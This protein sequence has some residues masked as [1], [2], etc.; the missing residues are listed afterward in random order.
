M[1]YTPSLFLITL[2]LLSSL[3]LFAVRFVKNELAR[4]R[5]DLIIFMQVTYAGV[6]ISHGWRL[7]PILIFAQF[8]S[9][10]IINLLIWENLRLR[11]LVGKSRKKQN[12]EEF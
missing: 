2:F 4:T 5:D 11:G 3:A 1:F 9:I 6:I 12:Y 8:L 10:L 7:D